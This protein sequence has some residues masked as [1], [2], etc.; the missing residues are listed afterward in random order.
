MSENTSSG[1][2]CASPS[3][4]TANDELVAWN[5]WYGRAAVV[6][7]VP[8]NE[9]ACPAHSRR[10]SCEMRNGVMSTSNRRIGRQR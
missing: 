8:K 3:S 1:A 5:T 7:M 9:T 6:I 10:K 2:S 4:P